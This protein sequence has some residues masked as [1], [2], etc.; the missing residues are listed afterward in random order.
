MQIYAKLVI[1]KAFKKVVN[2]VVMKFE[3]ET[4]NMQV[5]NIP[6]LQILCY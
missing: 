3:T 5:T 1:F 2:T 6:L 4:F